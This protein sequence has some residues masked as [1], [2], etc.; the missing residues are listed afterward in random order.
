MPGEVGPHDIETL[1][2]IVESFLYDTER[3]ASL[4]VD[5]AAHSRQTQT[6]DQGILKGLE[7]R[8]KDV[9][10]KLAN[11]VKAIAM[12]IMNEST[13]E[14]MASLKEQKME[15][16][17]AIQAENVKVALFE[18]ETSIGAFY[19]RFAHATMDRG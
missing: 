18:D 16:D 10:A 6:R 4:A 12:G 17:A 5:M 11:F 14:A 2:E 9:E 8:R 19:R 1:V 13:A 7:A 15:L 3:L